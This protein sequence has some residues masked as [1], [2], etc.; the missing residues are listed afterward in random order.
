MPIWFSSKRIAYVLNSHHYM[1]WISNKVLVWSNDFTIT[2]IKGQSYNQLVEEIAQ[3]NGY[4]VPVPDWVNEGAIVGLQGETQVVLEKYLQLK[5]Q[6]AKIAGIWIQDWVSK[7]E[8]LGYSRLWWN[9]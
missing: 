6:G 4:T 9:W 8:S 3:I 2:Y 1:A 5:R 7:R